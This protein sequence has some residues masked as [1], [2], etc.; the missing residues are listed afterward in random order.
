MKNCYIKFMELCDHQSY[1]KTII[2]KF[3][4]LL[5]TMEQ[6]CLILLYTFLPFISSKHLKDHPCL[7]EN[8][9]KDE[10]SIRFQTKTRCLTRYHLSPGLSAQVTCDSVSL[11]KFDGYHQ[12]CKGLV[13]KVQTGNGISEEFQ[14]CD[15]TTLKDRSA[16]RLQS[17][18]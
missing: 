8:T 6:F 18:S 5:L 12:N 7:I 1:T 15:S 9:I 3:F 16:L 14:I 10:R 13:L 11:N 4:F 2:L 17:Q